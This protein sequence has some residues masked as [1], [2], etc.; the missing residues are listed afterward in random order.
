MSKIVFI[1][2]SVLAIALNA[3]A[4]PDTI[5]VAD[6]RLMTSVLKPGLNQY[7][8]YFQNTKKKQQLGFWYWLRDIK[9]STRNGEQVFI[10]NQHWYGS[11]SAAY[12]T[13]YSINRTSDFSPVYHAELKR[14]K[15]SAY[16]WNAGKITGSDTVAQN[17]Q[18]DFS[19]DFKAPNF[20]WNLDIE[21]FEMLPLAANK[22]F[23]INF[24]DA[25]LTPPEYV[26]YTVT[27]SETIATLNNEQVDCW[28]LFTQSDYNGTHY[29]ETYW[30]TKKQHE[31]LKEED[32][33][34]GGYRYKVK[35]PVALPDLTTRFEK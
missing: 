26:T 21:T 8:V 30:I 19:L 13:V 34:P 1:I 11:D 33:Y 27:G 10:I 15:L 18:K 5:R 16:N 32:A 28:K 22:A 23:V 29:T 20:N 2:L 4:Q 7:L 6:K 9:V 3:A 14:G 17:S 31:F 25:G 35:M 24:Y 12:R